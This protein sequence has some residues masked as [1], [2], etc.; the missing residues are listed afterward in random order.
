VKHNLGL[1]VAEYVADFLLMPYVGM[2]VV[3]QAF[4]AS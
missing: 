3:K 2:V 4:K 1:G